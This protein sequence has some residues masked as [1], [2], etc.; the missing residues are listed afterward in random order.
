M[1]TSAREQVLGTPELLEAV[2]YQLCQIAPQIELLRARIVS[3]GFRAAITSS[4]CI[5]QLLFLR[6]ERATKRESWRLN[7]LLSKHFVPWFAGP[8]SDR[9]SMPTHKTLLLLDW[10]E[11]KREAFLRAEASWRNMLVVQPPPEQLSIIRFSHARLVNGEDKRQDASVSFAGSPAGGVTMG[12]LYDITESFVRLYPHSQFGVSIR[13]SDV[14]PPQ[15]DLHLLYSL[16]RCP[17]LPQRLDLVSRGAK[18]Q[19]EVDTLTWTPSRK[20]FPNAGA[21]LGLRLADDV[22]TDLTPERGGIGPYEFAEWKFN[23]VPI[24]A[25]ESD[26]R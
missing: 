16:D 21:V 25:L 11:S 15:I 2:L 14:G 6:A 8:L 20:E 22:R 19:R 17:N 26:V 12:F 4:P 13:N 23:R 10:M 3:H 7:P 24:S 9:W 18:S 1:M 5:Q